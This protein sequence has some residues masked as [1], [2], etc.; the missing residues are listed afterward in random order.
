MKQ[1]A[2]WLGKTA[3]GM[4]LLIVLT[5]VLLYVPPIQNYVARKA[6]AIASEKTG[7]DITFQ[8]IHITPLLDLDLSRL[9]ISQQGHRLV[10]V[11]RG[12]VD[13]DLGSILMGRMSVE[14][15]TLQEGAID[16]EALFA[17]FTLSGKLQEMQLKADEIDLRHHAVHLQQSTFAGC[18]LDIALRDTTTADTTEQ[19]AIPWRIASEGIVLRESKL[20]LTL[21]GDSIVLKTKLR[22]ASVENIEVDLEQKAYAIGK[23]RLQADYLGYDLNTQPR[24][25]NNALDI[26]HILL[27]DLSADVRQVRYVQQNNDATAHIRS[28]T[29]NERGGM[30]LTQMKGYL[31]YSDEGIEVKDLEM[32][33]PHSA[34]NGNIRAEW[35][36]MK[37]NQ[38]G[39]CNLD[40]NLE[41]G[42]QDVLWA[43]G[44]YLP[45]DVVAVYPDKPILASLRARGNVDH[46]EVEDLHIGMQDVVEI[47]SIGQIQHATSPQ[48]M[49]ADLQWD[50]ETKDLSALTR[51]ARLRDVRF[52]PMHIL[53]NTKLK[54]GNR[55][56]ADAQLHERQGLLSMK[57]MLDLKQKTY[58]AKASAK[59]L[60]LNHFL[61]K[62]SLYRFDGSARIQGTGWDITSPRTRMEARLIAESLRY[63]THTFRDLTLLG[64][65]KEGRGTLELESDNDILNLSACAEANV[66]RQID[67]LTFSMDLNEIDLFALGIARD[68]LK[69]SMILSLDG[70]SNLRDTHEMHGSIQ[71][72]ELVT[73]DSIFHPLDLFLSAALDPHSVRAQ[74]TAGDMDLELSSTECIDSILDKY[75]LLRDELKRELGNYHL[76]Q[77][78]LTTLLPNMNLHIR[79]GRNNPICNFL[80][81]LTGYSYEQMNL[82]LNTDAQTGVNGGGFVHALNTGGILLDTLTWKIYQDTTTVALDLRVKNGPKNRVVAFESLAHAELTSSGAKASLQFRDAK[83]K[84]G[85]DMGLTTDMTPEGMIVHFAPLNPIIAYRKFSINP[86]NF[87]ELTSDGRIQALVDL[88]ADDG[89]GM[90]LYST[91]NED[92]LQDLSLSVNNFNLGELSKAIPYM[93][94]IRGLLHGD[95]HYMQMDS[96]LSVST[97]LG[98]REMVYEGTRVGNLGLNGVYLPNADG[99]HYVDGI[100]TQNDQEILLLSGKYFLEDEQGQL[101]ASAMLSRLP[102]NLVNG[103]IPDRM[104]ELKGYVNGELNVSGSTS[105]PILNGALCTDSMYLTSDMY[106]VN[107]RFA[108]DTIRIHQSNINLDRIQAYSQG[109]NPMTLDG[110]ID[111]LDLEK[112]RMNLAIQAQ[113]YQLINAP[114]TKDAVAYGKVNVDMNGIMRGTLDDLRIYGRLTVLG[115]T[116]VTYVLKDS[117]LTVEDRLA[118]LVTFTDF[119]DTTEVVQP[120]PIQKQHV[121]MMMNISIEQAAQVNCLLS[122]DGTDY[123]RLEGGGDLTMSYNTRDGLRLNGRYTINSGEMSYTLISIVC[124]NF[125]LKNGSYVEFSGDMMNPRLNIAATERVKATYNDHN[126]PR[127]VTFDVG[128]NIT[129]TLE[130]MG[131]E[132]TLEAPEDMSVQN[133]LASMSSEE[134]GRVAVTMLATNMYITDMTA[135]GGFNTANALNSFLQSEIN[136]LVGRT[137]N[138]IDVNFGIEDKTLQTGTN[139]TNY[140]FSFAKRFWGNRIR[141]IIGGKVSTGSEA[142][143]N[144]ETIIDNVSLEYRLDRSATRYVKVYYN[145]N[146]ES[147]LEGELTEMGA[148]MVFRRKSARLADLFR[149]RTR[150]RETIKKEEEDKP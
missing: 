136:N 31:H 91:P 56:E 123:V 1:I 8:E 26:H 116:D 44:N 131:L 58:E 110:T 108:D 115:N 45:Q 109:K 60:Q 16:S 130:N 82:I 54:E 99:S 101:E 2:R 29:L 100:V 47:Q 132:F 135:T 118:D 140:S 83:G 15:L 137:Q 71:A 117:P 125:I 87:I 149:F 142:V 143:N 104:A 120:E 19:T 61:P 52:P 139:Q 39:T 49:N 9:R 106:S 147:L 113:N 80:Y 4:V 33:T 7:L 25:E 55:I 65:L 6:A 138:T 38:Q 13:L 148:G 42:S 73:K 24:S 5:A 21:P 145:R 107:L 17:Q 146:Y 62:D 72:I 96:T 150:R 76:S 40:V 77:D 63:K 85:V 69:T 86:D 112:I 84:K 64:K 28:L 81:R 22:E 133:E 92:A 95:I 36:A 93:P 48:R 98:V 3:L 97:D 51:Y 59:A 12:V 27:R 127:S 41:L 74:A 32:A 122:E 50:V 30:R 70:S 14:A 35:K 89:T 46:V 67:G 111:F 43:T 66:G 23:V 68:T 129:Q 105:H 94:D 103:Y 126:M 144:G 114:K 124:K 20:R 128:L 141:L 18:E 75:A 88:L 10:S 78:T 79:G 102:L 121:E 53:A 134:R 37:E 119:S 57:G 90:K 34:L 11:E